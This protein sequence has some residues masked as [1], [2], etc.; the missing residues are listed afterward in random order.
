MR[1]DRLRSQLQ[2]G[3]ISALI[4]KLDPKE[5]F[6]G[7]SMREAGDLDQVFGMP[8]LCPSNIEVYRQLIQGEI[9]GR[10]VLLCNHLHNSQHFCISTLYSVYHCSL[11]VTREPYQDGRCQY[12]V[13]HLPSPDV[14]DASEEPQ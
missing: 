14:Q 12:E 1:L 2:V 8:Q 7:F 3:F 13:L 4:P 6:V 10:H 11:R 9:L 5:S